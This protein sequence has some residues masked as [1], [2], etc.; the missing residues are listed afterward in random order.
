LVYDKLILSKVAEFVLV[1]HSC[2]EK[3]SENYFVAEQ[4]NYLSLPADFCFLKE[5]RVSLKSLIL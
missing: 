3:K 2:D 5:I 4:N 1:R